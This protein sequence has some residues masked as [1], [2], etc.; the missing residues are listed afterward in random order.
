MLRKVLTVEWYIRIPE[1]SRFALT[2]AAWNR[3]V[4]MTFLLFAPASKRWFDCARNTWYPRA[5]SNRFRATVYLSL[6]ISKQ[7][8]MYK[9]T[10][11]GWGFC[12][13]RNNQGLG[14]CYE[15]RPLA[16]LITLTSTLSISDITKTS[17]NNC[18]MYKNLEI[19][20]DTS[21][22]IFDKK[23]FAEHSFSLFGG[24]RLC[25][26]TSKTSESTASLSI[27]DRWTITVIGPQL[28]SAL[29]YSLL[30]FILL[31]DVLL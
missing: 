13:I 26:Q 1:K 15:P 11:I 17:S 31:R 22:Q 2:G 19:L 29:T 7:S 12:D 18:L 5:T 10:I 9:T 23:Q 28:N 21:L 24:I 16:R 30:I 6:Y 8:K 14:K 27:A 3:W 4:M 25:P 20:P